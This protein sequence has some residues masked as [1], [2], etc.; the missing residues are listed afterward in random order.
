[1]ALTCRLDTCLPRSFRGWRGFYINLL[2]R[3]GVF[4]AD[5]ACVQADAS[6]GIAAWSPIF[7]VA[8]NG[9]SDG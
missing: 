2:V 6:V 1:M 9:T 7:Q 3:D 4:E 5:A 8:T